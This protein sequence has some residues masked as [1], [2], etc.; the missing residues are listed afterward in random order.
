MDDERES[1]GVNDPLRAIFKQAGHH[2]APLHLENMVLARLGT[3]VLQVKAE[4]LIG[5]SG[6]LVG[7]LPIL[8]LVLYV[9]V[10]P[11]VP[12]TATPH[13]FDLVKSMGTSQFLK[14][15]A[16]PWAVGALVIVALFMLIDRLIGTRMAPEMVR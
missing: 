2:E 14:V 12:D 5:R 16:S 8:L 13:Y 6:W 7:G 15:I 9:V 4:P 1:I 10:S 3:S 11:T